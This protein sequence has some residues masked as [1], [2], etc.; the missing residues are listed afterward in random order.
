V[1]E[2]DLSFRTGQVIALIEADA[3]AGTDTWWKG[4]VEEPGGRMGREGVFP[5]NFVEVA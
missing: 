3:K 5:A 1:Q 4:A 2:G